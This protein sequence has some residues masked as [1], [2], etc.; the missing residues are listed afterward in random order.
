MVNIDSVKGIITKI[1]SRGQTK[2]FVVVITFVFLMV[3]CSVSVIN[4]ESHLF[5]SRPNNSSGKLRNGGKEY[6]SVKN[7]N[8]NNY[9]NYTVPLDFQNSTMIFNSIFAAL[10]QAG[11]DIH[12]L[13]VTFFPAVVPAGT[14]LY[15]S[16]SKTELPDGFEWL[17]F[18]HEFSYSFGM[19]YQRYGRN[20]TM[21]FGGP[22]PDM[23]NDTN[24]LDET[25]G[26]DERHG[27][28]GKN[29]KNEKNAPGRGR[30]GGA[31]MKNHLFTFKAK[32][33]LSRIIYLDGASAAK[34]QTG[35]MDTQKLL[36]DMIE[37][38]LNIT[39]DGNGDGSNNRYVMD[40]RKY[41]DRICTWGKPLGLQGYIRVE[42]GFELILCDFHNG[43][44]ELVSNV[45]MPMPHKIMGLPE[46][47]NKTKENGW[48]IGEDGK[49]IE[50]QL[51]L[52][53]RII[54]DKEDSWQ[55]LINKY[56]SA[57][58]FNWIQ[59][60]EIHDKG[61]NRV[62]LDYRYMVTGINRMYLDPN[63]Y[64]R[65]LL[66]DNMTMDLEQEM[67]NEL[68]QYV[69][70]DFEPNESID[71]QLIE[72]EIVD[73]F[74]PMIKIIHNI[75]N[76]DEYTTEQKALEVTRYTLNF[77][78]RFS[79]VGNDPL[80]SGIKFAI[81]EYVKPVGELSTT[82]DYLI[83]SAQVNIVTRIVETL[84][85]LND[86]LFRIVETNM[87]NVNEQELIPED[88]TKTI[89]SAAR[90][91]INKLKE[92]LYWIALDYECD[93][94]CA[95]DEICYTPSWGPSPLGFHREPGE[96]SSKWTEWDSTV[97][98]EVIPTT[99][100]CIKADTLIR[101]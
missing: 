85:T 62:Q 65:R 79:D 54:L 6:N 40:E 73:K 15:H 72:Q 23:H 42:V 84:Y 88:E 75:L 91:T 63:P 60:G 69:S 12:P 58:G 52:K 7:I 95:V 57:Q 41:A 64:A 17:A 25:S 32:K 37:W 1:I 35:E 66:N 81:Y 78:L 4:K 16:T 56:S 34:T 9:E 71:W 28:Y 49:F 101:A 61:E 22:P 14:L 30:R 97:E 39:D 99:L 89:V 74:A 27:S 92:E 76:S 21:R 33:D 46:P 48:P 10:K 51:T 87:F 53:Q 86:D 43:D 13:G 29:D 19:H 45:T 100:Q 2:M 36:N 83:W 82:A 3:L 94:K 44:V 26:K 5:P 31:S 93:H 59:A 80:G 55:T 18:D 11:S 70:R 96:N 38:K 24:S 20:S 98:R 77:K 67:F 8:W 47:V 50:E 68:E 90:E